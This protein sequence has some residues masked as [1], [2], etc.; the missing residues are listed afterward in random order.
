L[1]RIGRQQSLPPLNYALTH[2]RTRANEG[3]DGIF[4]NDNDRDDD[5]NDDNK[6]DDGDAV[7]EGEALHAT[8]A[9]E[10]ERSADAIAGGES[11][12]AD[13]DD[14]DWWPTPDIGISDNDVFDID[15]IVATVE[16]GVSD[17]DVFD[18]DQIVGVRDNVSDNSG[19]SVFD[20]DNIV[21]VGSGSC[22]GFET[23]ANYGSNSRGELKLNA[24]ST[25]TTIKTMTTTL[26]SAEGHVLAIG[27]SSSS[28]AAVAAAEGERD[29]DWYAC[30]I[31]RICD[32]QERISAA[33]AALAAERKRRERGQQ[34]SVKKSITAL[35]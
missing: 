26:A 16:I 10:S 23:V 4:D 11:E 2:T 29:D 7:V 1:F 12:F 14:H 22:N 32:E 35:D 31:A 8:V 34:T 33:Q 3:S 5:N 21:G 27:T 20:I 25:S 17:N 15:Q 28:A 6:S 24:S 19:T 30:E 13:A 18:V 9:G